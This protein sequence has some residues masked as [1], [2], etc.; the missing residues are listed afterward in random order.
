MHLELRYRVR[1]ARH[2]LHLRHRGGSRPADIALA[3]RAVEN[4]ERKAPTRQ[5]P[6][7]RGAARSSKLSILGLGIVDRARM[8]PEENCGRSAF[9]E[10][11]KE[12]M[13]PI[14]ER[15]KLFASQSCDS[16]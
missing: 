7:H 13:R 12:C 14:Q 3:R 1:S 9:S 8:V 4:S 15:I 6:A 16:W 5:R 11:S 10:E 2:L